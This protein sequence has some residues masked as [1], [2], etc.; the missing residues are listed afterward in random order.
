MYIIF[1]LENVVVLLKLE[2]RSHIE[3][4]MK[5]YINIKKF[6]NKSKNMPGN[7]PYSSR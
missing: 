7:S 3:E 1:I 6:D 4:N 2:I 5:L